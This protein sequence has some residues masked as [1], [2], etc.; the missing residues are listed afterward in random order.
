LKST[1]VRGGK[2]ATSALLLFHLAYLLFRSTFNR[3]MGP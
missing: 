1:L 2:H 3:E